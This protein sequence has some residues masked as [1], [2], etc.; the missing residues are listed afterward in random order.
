MPAQ[1]AIPSAD[2][3]PWLY[4]SIRLIKWLLMRLEDHAM[5]TSIIMRGLPFVLLVAGRIASK[6]LGPKSAIQAVN[7]SGWD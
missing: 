3:M 7:G 4:Q 5:P 6:S 1:H 2:A